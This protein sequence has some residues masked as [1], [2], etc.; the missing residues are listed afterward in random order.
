MVEKNTTI[1]KIL[2]VAFIIFILGI[3][4]IAKINIP[5]FPLWQVFLY[6]IIF[7]IIAFAIYF[8]IKKYSSKDKEEKDK[9]NNLPTAITL[10]QARELA[11]NAIKSKHYADYIHT[12]IISERVYHLGKNIKNNIYMLKAKGIYENN[13]YYIL[14]NMHKPEILKTILLNP[15]TESEIFQAMMYLAEQPMD[16]PNVR[17]IVNRNILTGNEQVIQEKLKDTEEKKEEEKKEDI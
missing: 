8:I 5:S 9:E 16:E 13:N 3:L 4:V 14:I 12:N 6:A 17:T 10:E 11:I 7:I 15:K 1:L 2:T